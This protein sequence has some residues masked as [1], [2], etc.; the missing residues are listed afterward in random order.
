MLNKKFVLK[1]LATALLIFNPQLVV[2]AATTND[3]SGNWQDIPQQELVYLQLEQGTVVLKLA[4]QFTPKNTQAFKTLVQ[5][6]FYNGLDFYRVIDQFVLQAGLMEGEKHPA[7]IKTDWPALPAEF[8]WPVRNSDPFTLVQ[9]DDLLAKQ[10]G[11]NQGFAV[12]RADG[13]EWLIHCPNV[14]N[15]AR[16]EDANSA[17]TDFALMQGQAPRHLDRNMSVV[18]KVIWGGPWLNLVK[19]G[20]VHSGGVIADPAKRSRIVSMT[21]GSDLTADAQLP[22]QWLDTASE[23]F[24]NRLA[25]SRARGNAFF[26]YKGNGALDICYQQVPVRLKPTKGSTTASL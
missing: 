26:H 6:G 19:R 10:T 9:Q 14:I 20:E 7:A 1:L 18:A 15:M 21:L 17:T 12:G 24:N 8:S 4:G 22:L 5:S 13:Q 16:S 3:N 25:Q 2:Q 11:F 23:E